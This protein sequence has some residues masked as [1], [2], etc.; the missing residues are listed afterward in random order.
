VPLRLACRTVLR[1]FGWLALLARSG[2]AED[3]EI[4]IVRRQVAVL[5]RQAGAPGLSRADR[6]VLAALARLLP[7]SRLRLIV[8]PRTVLRWHAGLVRRH[9]A[10]PRRAGAAPDRAAGAV[11][12]AGDGPRQPGLGLPAH[13]W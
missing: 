5:R 6:A 1:V 12:G 8:S 10:F 4:P 13:P 11:A 3:A 2:R 9:W 7:G